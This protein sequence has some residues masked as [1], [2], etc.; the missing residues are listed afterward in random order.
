M[1]QPDRVSRTVIKAGQDGASE[2]RSPGEPRTST[3]GSRAD[4][5]ASTDEG[6]GRESAEHELQR[7]SVPTT[8]RHGA[9]SKTPV[10]GVP[11]P[12]PPMSSRLIARPRAP[13]SALLASVRV[14]EQG[15][16]LSAFGDVD[17][18]SQLVAYVVQLMALVQAELSLDRF[19]ALHAELAGQRVLVFA[20]ATEVV[21]LMMRPGSEA[22]DLKQRLG[23]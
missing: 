21:G 1:L 14:D 20:D 7:L 17:L 11:P 18:L 22:Q 16:V 9:T 10:R 5:R 6:P 12:P 19:A 15:R 2:L 23:V 4:Q 13:E 3:L 8:P